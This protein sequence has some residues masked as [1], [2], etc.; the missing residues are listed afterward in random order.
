MIGFR[1][2]FDA[3]IRLGIRK[4]VFKIIICCVTCPLR[5]WFPRPSTVTVSS[6]GHIRVYVVTGIPSRHNTTFSLSPR[7]SACRDNSPRIRTWKHQ[8]C[9]AIS[10]FT[11]IPPRLKMTPFL[12]C[13][14]ARHRWHCCFLMVGYTNFGCWRNNQL[15]YQPTVN[16]SAGKKD[17]PRHHFF[18][19][20]SV[21]VG[22]V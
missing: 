18:K 7:R 1:P 21:S 17:F 6:C 20:R 12:Q 22:G 5:T 11:C 14:S 9:C 8:Q 15:F 19:C 2:K 3:W 13:G 4:G 10:L 16:S